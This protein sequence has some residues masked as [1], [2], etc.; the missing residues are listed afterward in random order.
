MIPSALAF[1]TAQAARRVPYA[2]SSPVAMPPKSLADAEKSQARPSGC[3][4]H[5]AERQHFV[6][7]VKPANWA[8]YRVWTMRGVSLPPVPVGSL[9]VALSRGQLPSG[10]RG[11]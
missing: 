8:S 4:P 2:L 3:S 11:A 10:L 5:V 9:I 7:R 1:A 6:Y